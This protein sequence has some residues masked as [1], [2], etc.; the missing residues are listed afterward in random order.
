METTLSSQENHSFLRKKAGY[1]FLD[2]L[3]LIS[4]KGSDLF[5]YLQTQTTNDV[6]ELKPGQGQ[7]N[8]I[9]DRKARVISTFSIHRTGEESAFMLV[10]AIQKENLLNHL[11]TFLFRED[12]TLTS[13]NH[14][15]L[16]LQGPRSSEIIETFTQNRKSIPEKPNDIIEFTFEGQSALAIAK[17][18]TGEEGCVLVFQTESEDTITRKLLEFEQQNLLIHIDHHAREVFRIESGIPSYGKDI[19]DK[20]I[21]PET[22]L[23]H[24]SVSYNKG[25]YIGQ[26][27][28]AKQKHRGTVRKRLVKVIIEGPSPRLGEPIKWNQTEIGTMRSSRADAGLAL[29]RIDRW[30]EAKTEGAMM[31]AGDARITPVKPDWASF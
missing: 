15:L 21:L 1:F 16:A 22:G 20:N 17:S 4:A 27:N 18:L 5:S 24:S 7:N 25:C 3:C 23:E 11:N 26:E 13:S 6:N 31:N 28:T 2:D 19:N 9:V 29:I 12:V 8:A 30:K 10:E 14:F